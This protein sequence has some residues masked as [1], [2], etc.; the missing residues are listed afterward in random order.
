MV[1]A[2]YAGCF[3]WISDFVLW[4]KNIGVS[5]EYIR[6]LLYDGELKFSLLAASEILLEIVA[7]YCPRILVPGASR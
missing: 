3:S 2:V 4:R 6:K 7:D 1:M 5:W